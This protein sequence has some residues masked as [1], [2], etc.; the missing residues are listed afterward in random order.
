MG[1]WQSFQDLEKKNAKKRG[2]Q[3]QLQHLAPQYAYLP[4]LL[5]ALNLKLS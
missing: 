1:N 4:H 5:I 3:L 2:I